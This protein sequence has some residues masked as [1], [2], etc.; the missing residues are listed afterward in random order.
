MAMLGDV[1]LNNVKQEQPDRSV[2]STDNP[3]EGGVDVT[4][5][6]QRK[7]ET[8]SIEGVVTGPDAANKLAQLKYH[9]DNGDLLKYV[10]RNVK[11]NVIIKDFSTTHDA[12][13]LG[14]FKFDMTL[15]EIRIA[16]P[17]IVKDLDKN[18]KAQVGENGN[19][20]QQQ[21][22][23]SAANKVHV[24]KSG[25][26]LSAIGDKYNVNYNKIYERNKGIIGNDP[27][28]IYPGQKLIIPA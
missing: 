21:P 6:T 14:G 7:P 20:G 19:K 23:G 1:F 24:V 28:M 10:Y 27:N 4:D 11:T 26:S 25:D 8:M 15:K 5:H 3:V 18:T 13:V 22:S 17:S 9:Q 16:K 12:E 2:K